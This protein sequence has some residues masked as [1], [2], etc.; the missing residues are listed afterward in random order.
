MDDLYWQTEKYWIEP[1]LRYIYHLW[2]RL[3]TIVLMSLDLWTIVVGN[4]TDTIDASPQNKLAYLHRGHNA[5]SAIAMSMGED[6]LSANV[7]TESPTEL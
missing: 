7:N 6:C 3:M 4:E 5:L 2:A 1:L